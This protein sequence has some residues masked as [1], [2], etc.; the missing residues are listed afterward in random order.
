MTP[1]TKEIV[2]RGRGENGFH[3]I[4]MASVS[5]E[6]TDEQLMVRVQQGHQAAFS[7]LYDLYVNRVYGMA[8]Q[9]LT[10][11]AEAEDVT[12][13]V[14]VSLWQR[15]STFQPAKGSLS[16]W[17]LT[18]AHNRI[19]DTLRRRRSAGEAQEAIIRDPTAASGV[20]PEDTAAIA[21]QN[22]EGRQVRQALETLPDDQREVITLS[23]YEGYSQS[24]ISQRLQV[25]LG[26]VKSRMRLAMNKLRIELRTSGG[27]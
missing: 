15:S 23:Y 7:A 4:Y 26:T 3:P 11:P 20:A 27:N 10:N 19:V 1:Q 8:L 18:V 14:F 17:L 16:S 5:Q 21:E 13:D 6:I 25:P 22:E 12:H 9:K 24:E 2:I